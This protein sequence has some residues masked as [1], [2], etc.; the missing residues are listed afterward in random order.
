MKRRHRLFPVLKHPGPASSWTPIAKSA[1][2]S[3]VIAT[4]EESS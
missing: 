4:Q 3:R 2:R 1:A